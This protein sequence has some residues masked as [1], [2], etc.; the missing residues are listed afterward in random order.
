MYIKVCCAA[1]DWLLSCVLTCL[2]YSGRTSLKHCW[3]WRRMASCSA[4]AARILS[5][6]LMELAQDGE[7]QRIRIMYIKPQC[8]N[9][10][11]HGG[12]V[13][14]G[15]VV[16]WSA[17]RWCGG[18]RHGGVVERGTVVWWSA[19]RWCGGARHGGVVE[20]GTVVWW[21]ATVVRLPRRG[22]W[23]EPRH[24]QEIVRMLKE[25]GE[26]VAMTGDGVID[27]PALKLADTGIAIGIAGTESQLDK[28]A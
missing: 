26:V 28:E 25:Q 23:G 6:L 17:A 4:F 16:W 8:G 10:Q 7:L 19:A 5:D 2:L 20:R 9:T 13:E 21:S 1:A 22:P 11:Q 3:S 15:T 24:K 14:R 12:V 27:A 18:A